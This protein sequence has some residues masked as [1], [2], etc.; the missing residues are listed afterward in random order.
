MFE[1]NSF[2]K[3]LSKIDRKNLRFWLPFNINKILKCNSINNSEKL[4]DIYFLVADHFEPFNKSVTR[5]VAV[6]RVKTW[7][8]K[9]PLIAGRFID[10]DGKH[11]KHTFFYPEE[12]YDK[13]ILTRISSLCREGWGDTEIHLHHGNDTSDGV[14]GKLVHF[15]S[16]LH[17]EHGLLRRCLET[18]EI[19]YGFIHGDWALDNSRLDGR[20]CGVN[21]EITVLKETGCYADFTLPSAPSDTQ[22]KIINSI[23]YATDDPDAPKSHDHGELV[24]VG[25]KPSGDLMMIQGPL[26]LNWKSR[27]IGIFPR[28]ENGDIS[29]AYRPT[30]QRA[31]LWIRCAPRID[32]EINKIFIK[33]HTHG[34]KEENLNVLLNEN[35]LTDMY[36]TIEEICE[37][38]Q[39]R[40][41]YV[42]AY[43]MYQVIK[44]IELNG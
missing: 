20:C 36:C 39:F 17:G 41:H 1:L 2:A 15:K 27:K 10:S 16:L 34:C 40:L 13:E 31:K 32:G 12:Q 42:T 18:R 3:L 30:I 23:Y 7:C 5:D 9:Y 11:P 19:I 24:R 25:K 22:T 29:Y 8:D 4:V 14:R 37:M 26:T 43:E 35:G 28:I 6:K 38:N 21:D 33:V 44:G